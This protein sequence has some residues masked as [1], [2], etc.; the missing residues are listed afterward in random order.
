MK[1]IKNILLFG[2][3]LAMLACGSRNTAEVIDHPISIDP[4]DSSVIKVHNATFKFR[5]YEWVINGRKIDLK[6]NREVE[7]YRVPVHDG[8][9]TI[10]FTNPN[11]RNTKELILCDFKKRKSYTIIFNT[12]CSDFN[13][14]SDDQY[15]GTSSIEFLLTGK[16]RRKLIGGVGDIQ[17]FTAVFLKENKSLSVRHREGSAM[18]PN[19]NKIFVGDFNR[20]LKECFFYNVVDPISEKKLA[21]FNWSD[22]NLLEF[23][24]V[25]LHDDSIRIEVNGQNNSS[26]LVKINKLTH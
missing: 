19:R 13:I 7:E 1:A 24:Y 3:L 21:P 17:S 10:L 12:C 9:D 26:K 18:F 15:G 8:F 4:G 16:P 2:S 14:N 23:S 22:Q 5:N 11:E 25:F 6:S 20:C